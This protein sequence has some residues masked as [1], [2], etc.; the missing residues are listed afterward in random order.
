MLPGHFTF[1]A[2]H[3]IDVELVFG[4]F[5]GRALLF[6][7]GHKHSPNKY[8]FE[9]DEDDKTNTLEKQFEFLKESIDLIAKSQ[10]LI[11]Q[12][13][14]VQIKPNAIELPNSLDEL[15]EI[16]FRSNARWLQMVD[17]EL[18]QRSANICITFLSTSN[19]ECLLFDWI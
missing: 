10:T 18:T 15:G 16:I 2:E 9:C 19:G 3:L 12:P 1:E 13:F 4:P 6:H 14:E 11:K 8:M 5:E 17:G 7:V